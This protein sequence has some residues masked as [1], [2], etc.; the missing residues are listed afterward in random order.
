MLVFR[1]AFSIHGIWA[2][3]ALAEGMIQFEPLAR[4]SCL[5][6]IE[7]GFG[8]N[9]LASRRSASPMITASSR[10]LPDPVLPE[11]QLAT[12]ASPDKK[13]AKH[14]DT[15]QLMVWKLQINVTHYEAFVNTGMCGPCNGC[16]FECNGASFNNG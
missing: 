14:I 9:I 12:L 11:I 6:N 8:A 1:D 2:T 10:L 16:F 3:N 4:S 13:V 7:G 5:S 15:P